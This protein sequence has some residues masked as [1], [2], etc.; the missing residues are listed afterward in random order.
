MTLI[1]G[2]LC[3]DGV[4][5][6]SDSAATLGFSG[7]YTIGQ[8]EVQKIRN[9]SDRILYS[10]TGGVGMAQLLTER[11]SRLWRDKILATGTPEAC[12]DKIGKAISEVVTPYMTTAQIVRQLTGDVGPSLCKSLV[13]FPVQNAPVLCQF[14][15]NG[16]PERATSDLP[17][18]ALGSGQSIADPFL[19]F[20][21]RVLWT[22]SKPTVAEGK[23][24]AVWTIDHVRRTNAG[25]VGGAIQLATLQPGTKE[26]VV[27]MLG[28]DDVEEHLQRIDA[29][30]RAF[31]AELRGATKA[32]QPS[33]P[34]IPDV[35]AAH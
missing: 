31:A 22:S 32:A 19:A 7:Q 30:E 4:V 9:L 16:V 27:K 23:L 5:M 21:R 12:M 24:A 2:I 17:F 28:Q 13:A 8:Q 6:A 35:P 15:Y 14:E 1:L 10:S 33:T 18:V 29:A 20:L 26:C 3:D 11:I 34:P 25:G